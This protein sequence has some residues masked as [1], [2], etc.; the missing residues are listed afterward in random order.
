MTPLPGKAPSASSVPILTFVLALALAGSPSLAIDLPP[1]FAHTTLIPDGGLGINAPTSIEWGPDGT[2]WIAQA[3]GTQ[4]NIWTWRDGSYAKVLDLPADSTGERGIHAIVIDP[5]Y[6]QNHY[7]WVYYTAPSD[8]AHNVL[9]RFTVV[10]DTPQ[11]EVRILEGPPLDDVFHN[12]G[13]LA[14]S[15]QGTLFVA[16]GDDL[17]S[18]VTSQDTFDLRGNLLHLQRDGSAAP[19]NPFPDGVG[20]D[21]RTYAWGFRNPYRCRMQPGLDNLFIADV[22]SF[23]EEEIS[24][25]VPGGN[26]GWAVIEGN[27]IPGLPGFV[28]PI[29][30]YVHTEAGAAI[31][32]GDFAPAGFHPDYEGHYFFG[33]YATGEFYR[34]ELD[35]SA[36]VVNVEVFAT[37]AGHPVDFEFGP[38]GALYYADRLQQGTGIG[39]IEYVGGANRQ[40]KAVAVAVPVSGIDPLV[41]TLDGSGS[42]DP[43]MD[44]LTYAWDLGDSTMATAATVMNTYPQGVYSAVLTVDDG[45]GLTDDAPPVRIVSGNRP[46]TTTITAPVDGSFYNAGDVINYSASATD[47]EEGTVGCSQFTSQV[48]FHHGLHTHPYLGPEQGSCSGSFSITTGGETSPDVWYELVMTAADTG[49][50]IGPEGTLSHPVAVNV[51]PNTANL[52]F[53]TLPNPNLQITLDTESFQAPV[54]FEG[55]VNLSRSFGV[56]DDQPFDGRRW[57]WLSWND[58][59]PK[60]R[61]ISFP[62]TDTTYTATF[63]CDVIVEVPGLSVEPGLLDGE[64]TLTW[65]SIID[66]CLT[67]TLDTYQVYASSSPIPAT[68]PGSFPDDPAFTLVGSTSGTSFSYSAAVTDNYFLV[69]AVGTDNKPGALG[70]YGK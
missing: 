20:G 25:A 33:D 46:P 60:E 48:I 61:Q 40:P 11:D 42:S 28:Y 52:S 47:P 5:D 13:C 51:Y 26:F 30:S 44:S 43:D 55:V 29:Y 37:N 19:G 27:N 66:D 22:G 6:L 36:N 49:V 3:G 32:G 64:Y 39:R 14:F 21:P 15:Q 16:M 18:S 59:G 67:Q 57:T 24:V 10:N 4:L 7:L 70:H 50:P 63:G 54:T 9:S 41:V 23:R 69:V 1:G 8:P 35:A 68:L 53:Q 65:A 2:L 31:I 17:G 56:V 62:A 34:M 12:G 58:S 45:N 38:D